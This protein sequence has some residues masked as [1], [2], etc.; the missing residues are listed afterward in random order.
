VLGEA[1]R[2]AAAE[3]GQAELVAAGTSLRQQFDFATYLERRRQ[4][5]SYDLRR[6]LSERGAAIET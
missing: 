4:D 5:A 2:I 1:S 6:H 3:R